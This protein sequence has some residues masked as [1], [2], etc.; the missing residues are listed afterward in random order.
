MRIELRGV[1]KSSKIEEKELTRIVDK[2][3]EKSNRLSAVRSSAASSKSSN[4]SSFD[5]GDSVDNIYHS[6]YESSDSSKYIYF[7]KA[8]NRSYNCNQNNEEE[9]ENKI[10]E[11]INRYLSSYY[12]IGT[13][14]EM[15]LENE[16]YTKEMQSIF[17]TRMKQ[18]W[19]LNYDNTCTDSNNIDESC[20]KSNVNTCDNKSYYNNYYKK[21]TYTNF[22]TFKNSVLSNDHLKFIYYFNTMFFPIK[23]MVITSIVNIL[24]INRKINI[25]KI[26]CKTLYRNIIKK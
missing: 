22:I 21:S 11:Y 23:N 1:K 25:K 7:D 17:N 12:L 3:N 24:N 19:W 14:D 8:H 6:S 9:Y 2:L 16:C 4:N 10:K 26:L 5:N 20:N 13:L 18:K 15:N